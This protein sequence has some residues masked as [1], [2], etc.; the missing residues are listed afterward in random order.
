MDRATS[1]IAPMQGPLLALLFLVHFLNQN[2]DIVAHAFQVLTQQL[3]LRLQ[4]FFL[5]IVLR[6]TNGTIS[7]S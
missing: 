2:V 5:F 6:Q 3:V 7:N 4:V 1:S